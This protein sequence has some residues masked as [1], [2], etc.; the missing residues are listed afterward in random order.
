M[1]EVTKNESDNLNN[2]LPVDYLTCLCLN[3]I[4]FLTLIS[5]FISM[6]LFNNWVAL[7]QANFHQLKIIN[8]RRATE[9]ST[10]DNHQDLETLN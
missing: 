1:M 10:P 3:L 4:C 9:A 2:P 8:E 6:K 7:F 5:P